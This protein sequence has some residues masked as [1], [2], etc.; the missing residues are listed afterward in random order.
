MDGEALE[1][2]EV[3]ARDSSSDANS[4]SGSGQVSGVS[5]EE[6]QRM[7]DAAADRAGN[8]VVASIEGDIATLGNTLSTSVA[9]G[10]VVQ[11]Q[12]EQYAQFSHLMASE[13]YTSVFVLG[14][15]ALLLG[16]VVAVG[17]TLHW[18]S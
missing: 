11:L 2:Q 16:A 3:N 7:L 9:E 8:S 18:R 14:L 4:S 12:D 6:L 10:G 17:L 13:L 5:V 15:L 1:V